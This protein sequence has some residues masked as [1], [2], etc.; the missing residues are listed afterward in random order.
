MLMKKNNYSLIYPKIVAGGFALLIAVG[1]ALLMLPVS[2]KQGS[3]AFIDALLDRKS[4]V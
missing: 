3:A 2:S 1:T 4:V